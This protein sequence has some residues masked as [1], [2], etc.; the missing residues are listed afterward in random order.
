M[1]TCAYDPISDQQWRP[2][3]K[4]ERE[5]DKLFSI[6]SV[7]CERI[8]CV[9]ADILQWARNPL[10]SHGDFHNL[11][12]EMR[13]N[14]NDN[15]NV[16]TH[17]EEQTYA[18]HK[19]NRPCGPKEDMIRQK[20]TDHDQTNHD[21][22]A[23]KVEGL[24]Q[25]QIA[26]V[27]CSHEKSGRNNS[28][29][30]IEKTQNC[31]GIKV[32]LFVDSRLAIYRKVESIELQQEYQTNVDLNI[33]NAFVQV[34]YTIKS[35][36]QLV[37]F[38]PVEF[39]P[40]IDYFE[41][42]QSITTAWPA[43]TM[44]PSNMTCGVY[45]T[46]KK[47]STFLTIDSISLSSTGLKCKLIQQFELHI[48]SKHLG[49]KLHWKSKWD[50]EVNDKLHAIN[51]KPGERALA[52]RKS[53]KKESILCRLRFSS[54]SEL[55]KEKRIPDDDPYQDSMNED[56]LGGS[57]SLSFPIRKSSHRSFFNEMHFVFGEY[58]LHT[59]FSRASITS[60][61]GSSSDSPKVEA[62]VQKFRK[63]LT[64]I[65]YLC[66]DVKVEPLLQPLS[67][68]TFS[69]KTA[70]TSDEARSDVGARGFW[71]TDTSLQR[72]KKESP[73]RKFYLF[74]SWATASH[75][76]LI[77]L[78]LPN[79]YRFTVQ[80]NLI[81]LR[82]AIAFPRFLRF[83]FKW[84]QFRQSVTLDWSPPHTSGKIPSKD[85]RQMYSLIQ[86]QWHQLVP[87]GSATNVPIAM[88]EAGPRW[89]MSNEE[90]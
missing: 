49:N 60:P 11:M 74:M 87:E 33:T 8:C 90:G 71:I 31:D 48:I 50:G 5:P 18:E 57:F 40:I 19:T 67:G 64:A 63:S 4:H 12:V 81:A 24:F 45:T 88:Q 41:D 9:I 25:H 44:Q 17:R 28:N 14:G 78:S 7:L 2:P 76:S 61:V 53:R 6:C 42:N 80:C 59:N 89:L 26:P 22:R 10:D 84:Q 30:T 56:F 75:S 36:E 47:P 32:T 27:V 72:R 66:V 62:K 55:K 39:R 46:Q 29:E 77:D 23:S 85:T 54:L 35:F 68:E 70:N 69:N 20:K 1:V 43:F 79:F 82:A 3:C 13:L 65:Q 15:D 37:D 38:I 83:K 16:R 34:D 21:A 73:D 51:P 58:A 86:R 52:Y